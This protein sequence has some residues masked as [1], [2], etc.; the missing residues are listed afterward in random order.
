VT[1]TRCF[2]GALFLIVELLFMVSFEF[3]GPALTSD[4]G[5]AGMIS[6]ILRIVLVI[7]PWAID[8]L[9]SLLSG[10]TLPRAIYLFIP[11]KPA[12]ELLQTGYGSRDLFN[13]FVT[14]AFTFFLSIAVL[15]F[16]GFVLAHTWREDENTLAR[17][18]PLR[19]LFER[20]RHSN[21]QWARLLKPRLET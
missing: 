4:P 12:L 17:F 6:N 2:A 15:L 8:R 5:G 3:L 14:I 13:F 21:R 1:W 16:S 20:I 9:S 7:W 18:R 10:S 19:W 11:L